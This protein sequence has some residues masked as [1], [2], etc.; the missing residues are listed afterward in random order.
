MDRHIQLAVCLLTV[1]FCAGCATGGVT[2]G[3]GVHPR[4]GLAKGSLLPEVI[5]GV[6]VAKDYTATA[7]RTV[8]VL[9]FA[10]QTDHVGIGEEVRRSFYNHFS[11]LPYRDTEL[12]RVDEWLGG[13]QEAMDRAPDLA[14][15]RGRGVDAVVIGTVSKVKKTFLGLYSRVSV[16][17]E[18]RMVATRTGEELWHCVHTAAEGGGGVAI[19]PINAAEKVLSASLNMREA[20]VQKVVT[21]LAQQA[22]ATVPTPPISK[23]A[24]PPV[25][26]VVTHDGGERILR[27]RDVLTVEA[28]GTP[29]CA[30]TVRLGLSGREA[31]LAEVEPGRY[32]GR[33]TVTGTEG[34]LRVPV[35]VQLM[36]EEGRLS[37]GVSILRD[38]R[39]DTEPPP[40]VKALS[41]RC[42]EGVVVLRWEDV[43]APDLA[44]WNIYR[45]T[46]RLS[47]YTVVGHSDD[48]HYRDAGLTNGTPYYYRVETVDQAGNPSPRS[49]PAMAVPVAPGPTPVAGVLAADRVWYAAASPYVV[50]S[51]M[52][53]SAGVTLTIEPGTTV[54]FTAGTGLYV[55]GTLRAVGSGKQEIHFQSVHDADPWRGL[56]F[57]ACRGDPSIVRYATIAGAEVGVRIEDASPSLVASRING[58]VDGIVVS[59]YGKP[60]IQGCAIRDNDGWG[61]TVDH[62]DPSIHQC[63]IRDNH[64]GGLFVDGGVPE[65][66]DNALIAN[67]PPQLRVREGRHDRLTIDRNWWGTPDWPAILAGLEGAIA[68]ETAYRLPPDAAGAAEESLIHRPRQAVAAGDLP[69]PREPAQDKETLVHLVRQAMKKRDYARAAWLLGQRQETVRNDSDLAMLYAFGLHELDDYDAAYTWAKVAADLEPTNAALRVKEG[70]YALDAKRPKDARAAWLAGLKVAPGKRQ[71][72]ELLAIVPE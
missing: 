53:V 30:A 45:S 46:E 20:A 25:V 39:I 3:D 69:T 4:Y 71:L 51:D 60:F 64:A 41:V 24:A 17:A 37:E 27:T 61:I 16:T 54:A 12:L 11:S 62:A 32:R 33:Y 10:N 40:A 43:S 36:D 7:P 70:L 8:A 38:V 66:V 68:L 34:T 47:G 44:G 65:V 50:Q 15:W 31:T 21:E 28:A 35:V 6:E 23:V 72:K 19:D 22:V 26:E 9:P 42:G 59:R 13:R 57:D 2:A 14:A 48:P 5:P 56:H 1:A 18:F 52:V 58:N 29:A 67:G 49:A 63:L 55:Q